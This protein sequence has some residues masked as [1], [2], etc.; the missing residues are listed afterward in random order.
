MGG[1]YLSETTEWIGNFHATP[2]ELFEWAAEEADDAVISL[3]MDISDAQQ[4]YERWWNGIK[5][6]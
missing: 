1:I 5:G 3:I 6:S 4:V 2:D